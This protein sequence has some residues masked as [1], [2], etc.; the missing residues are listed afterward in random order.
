MTLDE[1]LAVADQGMKWCRG[2]QAWQAVAAFG[3]DRS[4]GDGLATLC[5][6]AKNRRGRA[7]YQPVTTPR[8]SG[9]RRVSARDDDKLQARRRVN[10]LVEQ[11]LL[12][13]PN[14]VPC[15]DCS[16][17][18]DDRRHEYDHHLGYAAEHHEDVEAVCSRCH[19]TREQNR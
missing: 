7:S 18:A 17:L 4:R 10:Y 2:C 5:R 15:V 8:P 9:R 19:H 16:H 3:P 13:N 12:P 11:G 1:Y 14:D 6:E